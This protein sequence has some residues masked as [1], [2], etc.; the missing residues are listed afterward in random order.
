V[1]WWLPTSPLAL[2]T[3][4]SVLLAAV[5][6]GGTCGALGAFMVL[7]RQ[8]LLGDAI[9]HAVLPGVCLGFL[10]AGSRS[11]PMLLAGALVAGLLAAA[12][13][14]AIERTTLIKAGEAMGVVFSGFYGIGI[15]LMKVIDSLPVGGKAGLEKFLLGQ[16]V[17]VS[18]LDLLLMAVVAGVTLLC[19]AAFWRPLKAATFDEDFAH[20]LGINVTLV[21]QLVVLMLTTA[22]VI[23]IQA[24][25]VVLVSALLVTPAA[26][27]YL[28]T[29][30]LARMVGLSVIFGAG[31]SVLGAM[32]STAHPN[33]PTGALMVTVMGAAFVVVFLAAP[34]HGVIPRVVRVW[35][36]RR[37]TDAE[38]LLRTLYLVHEKRPTDDRRFGL[39]DVAILR[40]DPP[41]R[42]AAMAKVAAR[43]GWVDPESRDPLILTDAG[44]AEARRVVRNHRLWELFLTQEAKLAADHVHS[45]AERIEHV[46][47]PEIVKRLEEMLDHPTADPHGK[48]IPV[49]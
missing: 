31:C 38:N 30:R 16:I 7:R 33:L 1:T 34:R 41:A 14:A 6:L 37:K 3:Y 43:F 45:D 36:N 27:A 20:A 13:I 29:D 11:M 18:S 23:S 21:R 42:V 32:L 24:A 19:L 9:G 28:L 12:L 17:G 46:L 49:A 25:G 8:S 22:I 40:Q 26:T 15:V 4:E 10:A 39:S 35:Q 48:A 2:Q 44:L 5:L 47:P